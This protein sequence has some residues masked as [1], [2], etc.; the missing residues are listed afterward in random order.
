MILIDE[1]KDYIEN[2]AYEDY[3]RQ[4]D[5]Y[6][7]TCNFQGSVLIGLED[8]IILAKGY[9][10]ADEKEETLNTMNTTF[11]VGSITKQMTAVAI[12]QLQEQGKLSV[13]DP[14]T[15]YFPEFTK[16]ENITLRMLLQMRSGL[17][18]YINEMYNFYPRK[19]ADQLIEMEYNLEEV[20]RDLVLDYFYDTQL[21]SL[22]DQIFHYCNTNYYLL[23]KI[24][25]Q[26]SA[27]TYEDYLQDNLFTPGNMKNTNTDFQNTEAKGYDSE[28]RYYS[29]PKNIAFGCGDVNSNVVDLFK[30]DRALVNHLFM[31]KDSFEEFTTTQAGYGYGVFAD[32]LSIL[33]GGSTDVFNSYNIIYLSDNMTI[34]VLVNKPDD[35]LS[36]TVVAGNLRRFY[37]E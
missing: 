8:E 22:P 9:G 12:M 11:E 32:D 27:M 1:T 35:K 6:L 17:Y 24:I 23:G 31:S 28:G 15:K 2:D 16:G 4:V 5:D 10:Y 20:E 30:W 3:I 26:V 33:H 29:I 36:S 25:E 19:I 37:L 7:K 21:K 13:E 34:V 18:D 14:L